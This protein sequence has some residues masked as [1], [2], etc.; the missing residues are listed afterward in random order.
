MAAHLASIW[1]TVLRQ[2][3][4]ADRVLSFEPSSLDVLEPQ[5]FWALSQMYS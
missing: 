2:E 4:S 1:Q 5:Q 3:P